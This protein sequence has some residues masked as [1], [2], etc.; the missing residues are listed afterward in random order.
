MCHEMFYI[1]YKMLLCHLS[2][3]MD[4]V[5]NDSVGEVLLPHPPLPFCSIFPKYGKKSENPPPLCLLTFHVFAELTACSSAPD[6][7][8][9]YVTSSCMY[10]LFSFL[11]RTENITLVNN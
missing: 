4:G 9:L 3:G 5:L 2:R 1:S 10:V 11:N 7:C 8:C 6:V